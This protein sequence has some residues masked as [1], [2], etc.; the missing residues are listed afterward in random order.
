MT[1]NRIPCIVSQSLE[2]RTNYVKVNRLDLHLPKAHLPRTCGSSALYEG[3]Y[4]GLGVEKKK[5]P[6]LNPS[7]VSYET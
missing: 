6:S 4:T 7:F 3:M 2:L 5:R 1:T